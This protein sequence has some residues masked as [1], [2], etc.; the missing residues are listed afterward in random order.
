MYSLSVLQLLC[1]SL[2]RTSTAVISSFQIITQ[3]NDPI[4]AIYD[5]VAGNSSYNSVPGN[6]VGDYAPGQGPTACIDFANTTYLNYGNVGYNV[7]GMTNTAGVGTGVYTTPQVGASIVQAIQFQAGNDSADRDPLSITLEGSNATGTNL[8][9]GQD[10]T[11]LYAGATGLA[12]F[13]VTR[14][15]WGELQNFTNTESFTSYRMI[16]TSQRG[17]DYCTEFA[18]MHLYGIL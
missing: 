17:V 4:E 5:A 12:P 16:V 2:Y 8:Y 7:S 11:L 9:F 18:E 3:L 1:S 10:W 13:S 15:A 6:G 14:L